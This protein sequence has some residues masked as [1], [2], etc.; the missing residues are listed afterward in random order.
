MKKFSLVLAIL[1]MALV[2]GFAFVG[3]GNSATGDNGTTGGNSIDT[4]KLSGQWKNDANS[5]IVGF[6]NF[7]TN[8]TF[9]LWLGT[10]A[11]SVFNLSG[12]LNGNVVG[13]GDNS[14]KVSFEGEKLRVSESKG[15]YNG[16]D[17]LY[18]KQ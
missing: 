12:V 1:A 2:V 3:C 6:T 8:G 4:N 17:G 10:D 14:F 9:E 5:R 18:T 13:S 7:N 11:N 16:Y 15:I